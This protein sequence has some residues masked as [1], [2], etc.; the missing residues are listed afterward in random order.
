MMRAL[1]SAASGMMAQQ[2]NIDTIS[3]NLANVQSTGFKKQRVD[4]EDLLYAHMQ[5]PNTNATSGTQIG[6]GVRVTSTDRLWSQGTLLTT[7]NPYDFA[8]QGEGFFGV[9]TP[10]GVQYT[11]D[12]GFKY[13]ASKGEMVTANG[14]SLRTDRGFGLKI[15]KDVTGIEV[16]V[17]GKVSG[18][19]A[20][21]T[22]KD[23]GRIMLTRFLNPNGLKAMGANMYLETPI[24]GS[25]KVG[26]PGDDK[27]GFGGIAQGSLEKS[28]IN[29]VEEMINIVQAQRAFEMAQKGVQSADEMMR[30]TNQ[31]QKG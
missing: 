11:R 6:M 4:F 5:D 13:D 24:A 2:A 20:T 29:V 10:D 15:P 17:D 16:S 18:V 7:N 9:Q 30:M 1:Y 31:M 8:I 27:H 21:G 22:K 23:L 28:N 26:A 14:Y 12:G 25:K 3:N 19:D